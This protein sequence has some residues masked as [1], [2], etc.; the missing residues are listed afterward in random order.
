VPRG[1]QLQNEEMNLRWVCLTCKK[2]SFFVV[3]EISKI[4]YKLVKNDGVV[5]VTRG[6]YGYS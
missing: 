2:I 6:Q 1:I 3:F 4:R 5:V